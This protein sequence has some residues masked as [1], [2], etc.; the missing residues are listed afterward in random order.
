MSDLLTFAWKDVLSFLFIFVRV[1][2]TFALIPFFSA[3]LVPR[4]IT[5]IIAFFLSLVILPIVPTPAVAVQDVNV[6]TLIVLLAHEFLVGLCIGLAITVIFA[7]VQ[8]AGELIGY[9]MGFGIVNVV[10]PM[11]GTE[12]P[13]TANLLYILAFLLFLSFGGDHMLIK[14]LVESF[15]IIPVKAGLPQQAFLM[16]VISYV[17]E[18]FVIG[19]K[20]AAPVIGV[21]LLVNIAFA[22]MARAIP[23]MNVFIMAFPV[24]IAIGLAFMIVVVKMMPHFMSGALN[25][26]WS[27]LKAAMPLY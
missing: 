15:S 4:R 22:I 26:A 25:N 8:I 18:A 2:I 5:A 9:Q 24:T 11:T 17:A 20:V 10:D 27:F 19:V 21:L 1:G 14:A 7:G 13:I 12:A 16:A 6:L 23:Q 3:E